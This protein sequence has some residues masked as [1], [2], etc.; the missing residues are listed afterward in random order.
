MR[1]LVQ[2]KVVQ[3]SSLKKRVRC[4]DVGSAK[5][6]SVKQSPE[7]GSVSGCWFCQMWFSQAVSGKGFGV[8]MLVQLKVVQSSSLRKRVRCAD[9]GSAKSSSVKQSQEKGSVCGCWFS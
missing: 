5:S 3:S 6:G 4:A 2:L 9:V 7:K 1:M 8:R